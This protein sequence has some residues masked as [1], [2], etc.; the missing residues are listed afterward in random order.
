MCTTGLADPNTLSFRIR[1]TTCPSRYYAC[2]MYDFIV[3][4]HLFFSFLACFRRFDG[5]GREGSRRPLRLA[6]LAIL[7]WIGHLLNAEPQTKLHFRITHLH[8]M[9]IHWGGAT[10]GVNFT[11]ALSSDAYSFSGIALK[12]RIARCECSFFRDYSV[13]HVSL[14]EIQEWKTTCFSVH[15]WPSHKY[16]TGPYT[17]MILYMILEIAYTPCTCY[18]LCEVCTESCI[19][20]YIHMY[21]YDIAWWY[22]VR[23][24]SVWFLFSWIYNILENVF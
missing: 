11:S 7:G 5:S 13:K 8:I 6:W 16:V 3:T 12:W 22:Y 15:G 2:M 18:S 9:N 17:Y 4:S 24:Y 20:V 10:P 21:T 19:P 14:E 23:V 1:E